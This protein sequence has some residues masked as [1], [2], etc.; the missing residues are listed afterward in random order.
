MEEKIIEEFLSLNGYATEERKKRRKSHKGTQEFFTPY[1]LVKKMCD[2]IPEDG[3]KDKDK[4]FLEP[5]FGNGQFL[6]YIVYKRI[7]SGVNWKDTL[8]T[9]YGVELMED[10]VLKTKNRIIELFDKL[11]IDYNKEEA[12][13]IMNH[14]LV[15][16]DL[17][18]WDFENW[19]SL[20][21]KNEMK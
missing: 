14:H 5:C 16:S 9:L 4:T 8:N 20:E 10:N 18:L 21:N 15:C 11:Q 19:C 6:C 7:K 3:W 12:E 2:Y 13:E 17:F 1:S